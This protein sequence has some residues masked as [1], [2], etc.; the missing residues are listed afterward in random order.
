MRIILTGCNGKLGRATAS[1]LLQRG[2]AV[3]GI[4]VAPAHTPPAGGHHPVVVDDLRNPAAIHRAFEK[5]EGV[6]DAVVHLANHTNSM[7]APAEV[8]LREN[9]AMNSSVFTAAVQHGVHRL[10][11]SSSVQAMLASMENDGSFGHRIPQELPVSERIAPLPSNVY[12]VSKLLTEQMLTLMCA[13]AG[14]KLPTTPTAVS[15]R[16]PYILGQPQFEMAS[17]RTGASEF[18]WGGSEAFAYIHVEDAAMAL[19]LAAERPITGHEVVWC[20]A[21][22]PRAAET[23]AALVG[24]FYQG[25]PGADRAVAGSSLMD[26]SAAERLLGWKAARVLSLERLRLGVTPPGETGFAAAPR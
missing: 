18:M 2:H 6:P 25:V 24:R 9:L 26:C 21:P 23:V 3:V 8:V 7:V 11:F 17:K 4:D 1:A 5:F 20:A 15:V 12:G 13:N 22:D 16:L 14:F 10:V 19:V